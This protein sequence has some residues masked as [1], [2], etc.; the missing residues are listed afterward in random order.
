MKN[1]ISLL[2]IS[3]LFFSCN[4]DKSNCKLTYSQV[5]VQI[6]SGTTL[7][8]KEINGKTILKAQVSCFEE[9]DPDKPIDSLTHIIVS[10]HGTSTDASLVN[11]WKEVSLGKKLRMHNNNFVY[12]CDDHIGVTLLN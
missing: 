5:G 6:D 3:V 10:V 11:L 7:Q 2:I 4:K 1:I 8:W 12:I 9:N